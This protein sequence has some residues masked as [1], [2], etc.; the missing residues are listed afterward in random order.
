VQLV[1]CLY[2]QAISDLRGA[3]V[4]LEKGNVEA[5]TRGI[6]H[7]LKVVGHLQGSLD[8]ERG[9]NVARNLYRFYSLLRASL[10]EA[11]LKQSA[12][13][14]QQQILHLAQVRESWVEVERAAAASQ[15][16]LAGPAP[17]TP[18]ISSR[19]S[20]VTDWNA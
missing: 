20:P 16:S 2:E 17:A 19:E 11:Q 3:I 12:G 5:R 7:A 18:G 15:P 6:N 1:I 4:A 10:I 14:I 9:G 8:L 13:I